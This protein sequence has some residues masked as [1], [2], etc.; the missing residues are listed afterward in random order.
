[1][2]CAASWIG[3][4]HTWQSVWCALASTMMSASKV[5]SVRPHGTM[6]VQHSC[7]CS[8]AL[9]VSERMTRGSG[10]GAHVESCCPQSQQHDAHAP[11]SLS[12]VVISQRE[13]T[14]RLSVAFDQ[15]GQAMQ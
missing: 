3:R 4:C 13:Y 7:S 2:R 8:R 10:G 9:R 5:S 1:M 6:Q 15:P 14:T 12:S 11:G